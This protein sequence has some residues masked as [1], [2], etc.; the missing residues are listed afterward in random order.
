MR[1]VCT[2]DAV[3]RVIVSAYSRHNPREIST[4]PPPRILGGAGASV[5]PQ[6]GSSPRGRAPG[7]CAALCVS[8]RAAKTATSFLE[9]WRGKRA[10]SGACMHRAT[11]WVAS[12]AIA[13]GYR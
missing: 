9:L 13:H 12:A 2:R 10:E 6:V 8:L 7:A 5:D 1:T 4:L 11:L 3:H